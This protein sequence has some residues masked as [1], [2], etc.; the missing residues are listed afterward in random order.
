[1]KNVLDDP[2]DHMILECALAAEAD[3]NISG[4]AHLLA[5]GRWRN[6]DILNPSDEFARFS[7]LLGL[8]R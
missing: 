8:N 3:L 2:D 5:L 1:V 7:K 4:D 6:I